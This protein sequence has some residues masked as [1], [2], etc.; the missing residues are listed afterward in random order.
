[1]ANDSLLADSFVMKE[2]IAGPLKGI[3]LCN[4]MGTGKTIIAGLALEMH[5]TEIM[6]Q[7]GDVEMLDYRPQLL[8]MPNDLIPHAM[9]ELAAVFQGRLEFH[10]FASGD[11]TLPSNT[12][13]IPHDGWKAWNQEQR[14]N[15][16]NKEVRISLLR[17]SF[18]RL[19]ASG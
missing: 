15:R 18:D 4:A 3:A 6:E 13:V 14:K 12:H 9:K 17:Q 10:V 11:F 7:E 5:A 19:V 16:H 2:E 1:M 8:M